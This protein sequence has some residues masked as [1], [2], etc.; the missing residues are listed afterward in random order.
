VS[1]RGQ[2][3]GL[4]ALAASAL[5]LWP[6]QADQGRDAAVTGSLDDRSTLP[7]VELKEAPNPVTDAAAMSDP[8]VEA[9]AAEQPRP[10][11]RSAAVRSVPT[12]PAGVPESPR[13]LRFEAKTVRMT[14]DQADELARVEAQLRRAARSKRTGH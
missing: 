5:D 4:A 1:G 6:S 8:P 12:Q 7:A 3:R 9:D 10:T 2:G 11:G 14:A 13:Y